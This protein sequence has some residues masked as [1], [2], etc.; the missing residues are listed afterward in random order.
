VWHL[1]LTLAQWA[2]DGDG[3][4]TST[5]NARSLYATGPPL[6]VTSDRREELTTDDRAFTL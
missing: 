5:R 6:W 4:R 1:D 3:I 2:S